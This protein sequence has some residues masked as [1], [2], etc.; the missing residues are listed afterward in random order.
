MNTKINPE[1]GQAI[2]LLVISLVVLLGFTALALDGGMVYSDRRSAQNIVDTA[3][4]AG[5][6]SAASS[7][8]EL[9]ILYEDFGDKCDSSLEEIARQAAIARAGTNSHNI[10]TTGF[11]A[12]ATCVNGAPLKY[13][14]VET[15]LTTSTQTSFAHLLFNGPLQ[16]TV[17]AET[18]VY[19]ITSLYYGNSVVSLNDTCDPRGIDVRGTGD[20]YIVGGGVFS[21]SCIY[22]NGNITVHVSQDGGEGGGAINHVW[23]AVDDG[24]ETDG[25]AVFWPDPVEVDEPFQM[26]DIDVNCNGLDPRTDP[27]GLDPH[28]T[29]PIE[30]G[31]YP[32]INWQNGNLILEPGLYCVTGDISFSGGT[33]TTNSSFSSGVDPRDEERGVTFYSLNG[34]FSATSNVEVELYAPSICDGSVDNGCP[35]A[36]QNLLIYMENGDI[37]AR[38]GSTAYYTG[39]IYAPKGHVEAGGNTAQGSQYHVQLIGWTVWLHGTPG[40]EFTFNSD[41]NYKIPAMMDLHR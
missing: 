30:P 10:D 24:F 19:P 32:S 28:A 20:I 9:Q 21:N 2:V 6:G 5:G 3:A 27:N 14:K 39:T 36:I 15:S 38:G 1:S 12:V 18:R 7:L 11:D 8:V 13:I 34:S 29:V 4:L 16:N 26:Y 41:E 23:P 33:V 17:H 40:I 37:D 22:G 31:I 35:P 25:G